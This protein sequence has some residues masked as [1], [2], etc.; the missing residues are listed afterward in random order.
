MKNG[1]YETI[2]N[3]SMANLSAEDMQKLYRTE[4]FI[5]ANYDIV[6]A[7]DREMSTNYLSTALLETA[8]IEMPGYNYLLKALNEKYP[9]ISTMGV[10]DSTGCRFDCVS[11][12]P[13][14][15]G[16]LL[17]YSYLIYNNL[18][19]KEERRA[20]VFDHPLPAYLPAAEE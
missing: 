11:A 12:L 10:F 1:F 5:W 19:G 4:Y 9:V 18:F 8:G 3:S 14:D 20:S 6:E 13:D 15:D 2:L 7:Q 16:M 17:G